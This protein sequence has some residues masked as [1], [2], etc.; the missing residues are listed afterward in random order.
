MRVILL[1]T[2]VQ[3]GYSAISFCCHGLANQ[4]IVQFQFSTIKFENIIN[5][6]YHHMYEEEEYKISSK[7]TRTSY[8]SYYM[9]WTR[10][11]FLM[12]F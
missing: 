12:L 11:V 7:A 6:Q 1:S 9:I 3:N 2:G 4:L 10:G 5:L 8:I